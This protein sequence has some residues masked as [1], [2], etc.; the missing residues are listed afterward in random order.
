MLPNRLLSSFV[1][2]VAGLT[3]SLAQ[4]SEYVRISIPNNDFE[5]ARSWMGVD[6]YHQHGDATIVEIRSGILPQLDQYGITYQILVNDLNSF[7]QD[8]NNSIDPRSDSDDCHQEA[9]TPDNFRL[10]SMGGYLPLEEMKQE[11]DKMHELYPD[12]ITEALPISEFRSYED[13]PILWTGITGTGGS[14]NKK[15]VLYTGL[16]H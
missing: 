13:R 3:T 16:H 11:L 9:G 15:N 6:H 12:L 1:F 8:Q 14:G 10:G 4:I 7:Y 2:F 5:Y